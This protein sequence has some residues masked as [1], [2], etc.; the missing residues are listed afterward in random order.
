M[1]SEIEHHLDALSKRFIERKKLPDIEV[2]EAARLCREALAAGSEGFVVFWQFATALPPEAAAKALSEHWVHLD[3]AQ[4]QNVFARLQRLYDSVGKRM[5]LRLAVSLRKTEVDG[6]RRVLTQGCAA[7]TTGKN[8]GPSGKELTIFQNELLAGRE[9]ALVNFDFTQATRA[10][11]GP[12]LACIAATIVGRS[13]RDVPSLIPGAP[14]VI[15]WLWKEDLFAKWSPEQ[16]EAVFAVI[17]RW[18]Q[19]IKDELAALLEPLPEAFVFLR[20]SEEIAPATDAVAAPAIPDV[21][22][23][24]Q[25]GKPTA[26]AENPVA[27]PAVPEVHT[28]PEPSKQTAAPKAPAAASAKAAPDVE[29]PATKAAAPATSLPVSRGIVSPKDLLG[30]LGEAIR[31]LEGRVEEFRD[32]ARRQEAAS[33]ELRTHLAITQ[34]DLAQAGE[35]ERML[36]NQLEAEGKSRR[37]AE[38]AV[39]AQQEKIDQLGGELA[40]A[41]EEHNH[42]ADALAARVSVESGRHLEAFQNALADKL[43]LEWRDFQDVSE[44]PMSPDI[45]NSHRRQ[46]R[47]IFALLE[48]EGVSVN[49]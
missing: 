32:E 7:L 45:G 4:R 18:P 20:D 5:R 43:R 17:K 8:N 23:F 22:T 11:V 29:H 3:E 30:Q 33:R 47:G 25:P 15:K 16:S 48:D 19:R 1:I 27:T 12:M 6:A 35:R 9:P 14:R 37:M 21:D 36:R 34:R 2:A 46:L 49:R 10:E 41:R 42:E 13:E 44:L 24:S 40:R 26:A 28:R 31:L 38:D 39:R